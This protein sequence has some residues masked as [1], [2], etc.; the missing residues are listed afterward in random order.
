MPSFENIYQ[1]QRQSLAKQVNSN[2]GY[3]DVVKK[4]KLYINHFLRVMNM[5]VQRGDFR[6]DTP[7]FFGLSNGHS[8]QPG[9]STEIEI[10]NWGK[11]I[12]DGEAARQRAGRTSVTNPTIAVVKVHYETFIDALQYQKTLHKRTND[13]SCQISDLRISA[14]DII[15]N[16][17]NEVETTYINL[18]E[19]IKRKEAEVY[20]L[21]YVFRKSELDRIETGLTGVI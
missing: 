5:A 14:D 9:L 18:P 7:E 21:V 1:L 11:R 17:W 12:I 4:A 16:I 15:L 8:A 3:Q 13:Y 2:N 19:D 6:K 10:I 20:G